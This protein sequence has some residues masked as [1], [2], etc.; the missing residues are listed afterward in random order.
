M[1]WSRPRAHPII[2]TPRGRK[3]FEHFTIRSCPKG[4]P[5][6]PRSPSCNRHTSDRQARAFLPPY[7]LSAVRCQFLAFISAF[8]CPFSVALRF[9]LRHRISLAR[10]A[11]AKLPRRFC[12]CGNINTNDSLPAGIVSNN[13]S[14]SD[15]FYLSLVEQKQLN[16]HGMAAL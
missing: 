14:A 2:G 13:G 10:K 6:P 15:V 9:L 1:G 12:W 5:T 11:I 8:S 4:R 7:S 3:H 16:V